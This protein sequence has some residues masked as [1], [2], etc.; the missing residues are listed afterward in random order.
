MP[1]FDLFQRLEW[2]T[3]DWRVRQAFRW[4][5]PVATNL[6]AVFIDDDSLKLINDAFKFK[7]PW[8]QQLYGRLVKRLNSQ[9]AQAI[10]FD[11][12]SRELDEPNPHRDVP[13]ANGGSMSSDDFYARQLRDSS[14][15]VLSAFGETIGNQWRALM[16]ADIFRTNTWAV[17]HATSDQDAD[18]ILRRAK[19]Y[20]DDPDH[21]RLWHLG[22]ILAAKELGIDLSQAVVASDRITLRGSGGVQRVIP[23]DKDGFFYINWNLQYND[24]R[25]VK[26]SFEEALG[27]GESDEP[28]NW[29]GKL[30]VVG[31]VGSGNN[32]SDV[33]AT[34]LS[35][36]TYLVSKH[37]NVANSVITGRFVRL[38]PYLVE[39]LL[40]L[41]LGVVSALMTWCLRAPMQSVWV[42][43]LGL[44]Y[45]AVSLWLYV[46]F[47]FWLP[48]VL[49]V[50]GGLVLNHVGVVTYQVIF[51]QREKRHIKAVFQK[52]VS[53]NVVNELLD[54]EQINLG[55]ARRQITVLFADVRGFTE[56]TDVVQARAEQ[57]VKEHQ[58]AGEDAEH[59]F[60]AQARETLATVNAYL[61][62]IADQ[63][64]KHDG[65]LDKY[66]G[67]CVMA[68]WGAP[69][70][71][72]QHALC[73]VRAAVDAQR[74]MYELNQRRFSENKRREDE[75]SRRTAAGE[76]PLEMLALLTLGTGINSGT[77]MVGMMGSE[78]HIVNYTVFGR[79]VN[80]AS[81]LEAVS[82]RSRIIIGESTYLELQRTDAVLAATCIEQ[83]PVTVKG[84]RTA[85]RIFE[86]PWK[87]A[88]QPAPSPT[89]LAPASK[90]V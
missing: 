81:R 13:L 83:A 19:P 50:L 80:L 35:K 72:D 32:I 40:I 7:W 6:G 87:A 62:A 12:L 5:E 17:G 60:D 69:M 75:N 15:V 66:I 86:V 79:E 18:G 14:N 1:G 71:N 34:S 49:P 3:Y 11:I 23:L 21:G 89:V 4:P 76:P 85:V 36:Q 78:A 88:A 74:A 52:L 63:V 29:R 10:G 67:D 55:G 43:A 73:C 70:S 9:G 37:W 30:V 58:L 31:S 54:A 41:V 26:S 59:Y 56:M 8:P 65:T 2:I 48:I 90:P 61:A 57:Y 45:V 46:Q 44:V 39:L 27:L 53:P 33:G 82:G 28:P 38:C 16:P 22:I 42:A 20:K 68:F 64:K 25:I 47:R 77:A 51:E 24:R 84:I